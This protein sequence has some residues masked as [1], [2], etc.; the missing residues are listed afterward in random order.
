MKYDAII[1][2]GAAVCRGGK[3]SPA[4]RRRVMHGIRLFRQ[5]KADCL[6][7]T[8]G[9]GKYPPA[10]AAVMRQLALAQGIAGE[11][12]VT[13]EKGDS[14]FASAA[15]CARI[16]QEHHWQS[17]LIVS[18][19]FHILR[20][21]FIFRLFGIR[22]EGNGTKEGRTDIGPLRWWLWHVREGIALLW[23]GIRYVHGRVKQKTEVV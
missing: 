19:S 7:F 9:V 18:D 13:E 12:I 5:E 23:Y 11:R 15:C 17:A 2:M 16:M 4:L 21:V 14:T 1:V 3:A 6:L 20:S 10:E 8:G 22:T